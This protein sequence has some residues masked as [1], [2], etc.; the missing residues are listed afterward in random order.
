MIKVFLGIGTNLGD[1]KANLQQA[2]ELLSEYVGEVIAVS[3]FYASAPWGFDSENDFLNAV[4]VLETDLSPQKVLSKTKE[5]ELKMGRKS[6]TITSLYADR[7]IDIDILF[8]G[9]LVVNLPEL[10][11]PH[12]FIQERDFVLCPLSEIAPELIHPVL[13]KNIKTLWTELQDGR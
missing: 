11:I 2:V 1:K 10:K 3:S 6:K 4:L 7:I 12:P 13:N 9:N 8:Y 5:I